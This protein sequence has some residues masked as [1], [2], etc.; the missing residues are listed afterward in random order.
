MSGLLSNYL[1]G[2]FNTYLPNG[3]FLPK[4]SNKWNK[5]IASLNLL[6]FRDINDFVNQG[7]ISTKINGLQDDGT[8][9]QIM[10]K[11]DSGQRITNRTKTYQGSIDLQENLEK[12]I[13]L[14][15]KLRTS[16][17]NW[18]ILY[19]NIIEYRE[20]KSSPVYLPDVHSQIMN[21]N[22]DIIC[23]IIYKNIRPVELTPLEFG[24]SDS[25]IFSRDYTLTLS[26]NEFELKVGF[27]K[28]RN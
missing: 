5:V 7:I 28:T 6:P 22:D 13:S 23:S 2:K 9:K 25:S 21:Y 24:S 4:T 11:F 19:E 8:E 26:Y 18:F 15:F 3:F 1:G 27:D 14:T 16:M 12:T 17:M 10:P 20:D